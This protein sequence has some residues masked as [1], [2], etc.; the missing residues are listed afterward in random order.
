MGVATFGFRPFVTRSCSHL[1]VYDKDGN[2]EHQLNCTL[3]H[4]IMPTIHFSVGIGQCKFILSER[5]G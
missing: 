2:S 5:E 1:S 4:S 3:L